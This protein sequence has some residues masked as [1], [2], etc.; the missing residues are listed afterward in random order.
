METISWTDDYKSKLLNRVNLT[1][2]MWYFDKKICNHGIKIVQWPSERI[3]KNS[4]KMWCLLLRIDGK[5]DIKA[6]EITNR[7]FFTAR[8]FPVE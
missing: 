6:V 7:F 8:N 1:T 5:L 2:E 3:L 4:D